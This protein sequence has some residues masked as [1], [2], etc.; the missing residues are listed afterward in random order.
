MTVAAGDF[1][2]DGI[3]DIVTG[4][5]L[6]GSP[7]FR[8]FDGVD[9]S[10]LGTFSN[11]TGF[12]FT[13]E[14]GVATGDVNL[15]GIDD[16]ALTAGGRS[17]LFQTQI[18]NLDR[19]SWATPASGSFSPFG[20][21]YTGHLSASVFTPKLAAFPAIAYTATGSHGLSLIDVSDPELPRQVG[22][23]A[24]FGGTGNVNLGGGADF[25]G[26][27][28]TDP[29]VSRGSGL[30][31]QFVGAQGS[32]INVVTQG[33]PNPYGNGTPGFVEGLERGRPHLRPRPNSSGPA[34][35]HVPHPRLRARPGR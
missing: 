27:G 1:N 11:L 26:D 25:D 35:R 24:P 23:T 4:T 19:V 12:G 10:L 22:T 28:L 16:I 9:Q 17:V 14:V 13:G 29:I 34:R 32:V 30:D 31:V 21:G 20:D 6:F 33:L 15:D 7:Q 8:V 2:R 18:D 3:A 5:D